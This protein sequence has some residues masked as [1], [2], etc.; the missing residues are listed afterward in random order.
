MKHLRFG[1]SR[2]RNAQVISHVLSLDPDAGWHGQIPVFTPKYE[3]LYPLTNK[4]ARNG[5][6]SGVEKRRV[7]S[8]LFGKCE[9]CGAPT[10]EWID[11]YLLTAGFYCDGC[12]KDYPLGSYLELE[13]NRKLPNSIVS[14]YQG[15]LGDDPEFA[16]FRLWQPGTFTHLAAAMMTGKTTEIYKLMTDLAI[17]GLG[18]GIIVP[19]NISLARFFAHHLR[20]R[21]GYRAWGLWHEGCHESDKFIGTYGAIV[22]PPSLPR[23]VKSADDAGVRRLYIAIDE[24]DFGYNLLSLSIEQATAVKKC[25]RD[26]LNTT[27]LVVLGQTEFALALEALAEELECEHIQGFYN[28]AKP[29]D[30]N[31]VMHKYPN[32]PGISNVMLCGVIDEISNILSAGYNAYAFCSSRRGGDI[33]ADVFQHENPIIYTAYTKGDP[34]ADALLKNQRLTDSRLFIATAA[35]GVGISIL[36]PKARTVVENGLIYGSRDASMSGQK[37][38]RDRGRC[39]VSYHYAEYNLPLPVRPTGKRES[40][41]LS[42]STQSG[43]VTICASTH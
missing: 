29:A 18:K 32:T 28:T 8:T 17:Q 39:G 13:L 5:Q 22:C 35:A 4:F 11:R 16:D 15:F 12:H 21:D 6:P 25:L 37:C 2:K 40:Q 24:V 34:R 27:G 31:V 38:V 42:R 20:Q 23:A 41:H 3:Y 43:C 19:P 33:I 7:W 1:I 26:A 10:A 36:D 9:V 14:G 30:G